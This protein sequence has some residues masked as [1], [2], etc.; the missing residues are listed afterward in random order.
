MN[1]YKMWGCGRFCLVMTEVGVPMVFWDSDSWSFVE[2]GQSTRPCYGKSA[3]ERGGVGAK[4]VHPE[5]S[6]FLYARYSS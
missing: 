3:W 6:N 5:N 1:L 4:S 2:R